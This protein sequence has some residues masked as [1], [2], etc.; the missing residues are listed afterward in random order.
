MNS[1]PSSHI[2]S[3]EIPPNHPPGS[4]INVRTDDGR[5]YELTV[6]P[7]TYPGDKISIEILDDTEGGSTVVMAQ[8]GDEKMMNNGNKACLGAA[9]AGGVIGCLLVGPLTGIVVAGA[10]LYASTR[11]DDIGSTA[12]SAGNVAV[13]AYDKSVE[14]AEKYHIKEKVVE[15]GKAT[16]NKAKE[17][18]DE[19]KIYDRAKEATAGVVKGAQDL[20]RKYDISGKT[21]R[22]LM[23]GAK[24]ATSALASLGEKNDQRRVNAPL[25]AEPYIPR[26]TR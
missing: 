4:I 5:I 20:D 7:H 17:L 21:A 11:E 13:S 24:A 16:Y 19:Y 9:A 15:A 6:P 26:N 22:A 14:A 8:Q 3:V 1:T 12:R 23:S 18:D 10:A 25:E 2:I